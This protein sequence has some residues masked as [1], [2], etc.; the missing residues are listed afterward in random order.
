MENQNNQNNINH[1]SNK[2]L[3]SALIFVLLCIFIDISQTCHSINL[4]KDKYH[5]MDLQ[6]FKKIVLYK[7][8]FD[9][10][11]EFHIL[12][13][14]LDLIFLIFLS[15][16]LNNLYQSFFKKLKFAFLYFNYLFFGPFLLG[17]VSLCMKYGN[18][19]T[20]IYDP[21]EKANVALHHGNIFI[22]F[23]YIFISF[24]VAIIAPIFYS[25][26][27]FDD[28]IKFK[29][30]GNFLLGKIFW[31][32]A[33][34]Y[35]DG[36]NHINNIGNEGINNNAQEIQNNILPIDDYLLLNNMID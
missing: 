31:Y 3:I 34:K 15:M 8:L 35:F 6:L 12:I 29:R 11:K 7:G 2:F 21:K 27:Y 32:F 1:C 25:Y 10:Y 14:F 30:N 23:I 5:K 36:F 13:L 28:S 16:E 33:L 18:E 24:T 22:I 20:F 19:L 26:K 9:I 4:I 17:V